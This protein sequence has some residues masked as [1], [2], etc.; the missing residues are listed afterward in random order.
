MT[1][2][3]A[4][5]L[6]RIGAADELGIASRRADGS[7]R[8]F[9]TIWGVRLG[10]DLY[11]RSA[12]GYDNPWFQRAL[13]SGEGR[14]RADGVERDVAFEQPGPEV[15]ETSTA[16]TTPNTIAMGRGRSGPS[17]RRRRPG[18]RCGSCPAEA[19][20]RRSERSSGHMNP[21]ARVNDVTRPAAGT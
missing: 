15:E 12:Y 1:G 2:W 13:A 6:A 14:V 17:S 5:E 11:I 18:R 20:P 10:D 9:V 16:P 21:G 19:E 4:D 3:S 7:L 8:P